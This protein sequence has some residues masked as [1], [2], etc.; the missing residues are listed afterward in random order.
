MKNAKEK[1]QIKAMDVKELQKKIE[2]TRKEL[3]SI[4]LNAATTHIK[5]YSQF[6]KLRKSIARA[7]TCLTQK[8]SS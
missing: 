8:F 1:D 2:D 6:K 3:F 4:R 5:D 7:L